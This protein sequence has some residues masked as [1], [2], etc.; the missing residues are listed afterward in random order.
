MDWYIWECVILKVNQDP[1]LNFP[2]SQGYSNAKMVAIAFCGARKAVRDVFGVR[3]KHAEQ[4]QSL[5]VY[6]GSLN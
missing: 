4:W 1:I 6:S 2:S 5:W 3:E